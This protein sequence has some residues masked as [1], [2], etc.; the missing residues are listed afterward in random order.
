MIMKL[1]AR[2]LSL[3]LLLLALAVPGAAQISTGTVV[4]TVKDAQ[5]GVIPGATVIL[6]SEARGTRSAPA[7]TDERGDFVFV[8]M[9]ADTYT[10]E[11]SLPS[12][13][14]LKRSGVAVSPG[15]RI[16]IGT[17][18]LEIGGAT[19]TVEVK[20]EAPQIQSSS[21]ERSFSVNTDAVTNLPIATRNFADLINLTPGVV[22]GNRAGDSASTGG[23]ANNFMMDGVSTMEPGSNRLMIG[24]NVESIAEVKV[25]TSSYQA[26]FGRSS[27]LQVTAV[28]KSGTNR[29]RGSMY[30]VERNSDWNSNSR[31]NILNGDPKTTSRSRDWGYSIGGPV[32]KP[33]G[34]NKLFFFYAQEFQPRTT[35]NNVVR[36]RVP[37]A[38]ERAGDFSQTTDNNGALFPYI[39]DPLLTGTC[40]ATNQSACFA[41]GGVLG[42]IP[43]SRLY[44]IGQNILNLYPLPNIANV[45]AGQA[46]N[47]ELTRPEQ[48]IT[49]WQPAVR[50]DYQPMASLRGT[51]KYASWGQPSTPVIGSLP[52]FND[53]QMNDP[54]VPL[55]SASATY[56]ITPST[57][58]EVNVGHASHRQAGCGLNGTGANFCTAGFP[59]NPVSSRANT[60][61]T[62]LP[63]LFPD[64]NIV[65]PSYYQFE[66]LNEVDTPIWD[67]SRVLLPPAFQW[68]G[69]V[70]NSA[71]TPPNNVYP[72][73]ADFSAVTDFSGSVTKVLGRHTIKSGYY[74]QYA[75]KRQNQGNPFGTL[76]FGNDTNNPLD[77]QFGYANAVLGVFSSYQQASRFVEG[78]YVYNNDEAYIQDNWK[79]TSRLTLDYG[80]RFVHQ[81]P[82]YD[83][84]G[85]ASNFLP[86]KYAI[87]SAP[88]L[89]VAG[90]ANNVYPCSGANRQAMNPAT[91]EFLGPNSTLAIGAIVPNTGSPTNGLFR[92][93]EGITKTNFKWPALALAPRFGMAYDL[94]A[95]QKIVL[96]GGAGLFFDRP[97]GNS[98]FAQVLNPP[99]LQSVTVRYGQLQTLGSAGLTTTTPPALNVNEYDD[100][101]P[102]SWQ[103]NGGVQ[104]ALPWA[105]TLDTSYVGQHQFNVLQQLNLNA[106]DL[107]A[108]FLEQNRDPTLAA[109]STP[110]ATAVATDQ[111]RAIRGYNSITQTTGWL[112][113]TYHSIQL[114]VQR[115]FRNGVSFGFNDIIGLYDRQ[116]VAPRLQHAADG[117]FTVRDDQA[118][119]NKLLGNNRP[120][121][122]IMKAN[123]IWDLPD[124]KSSGAALRALGL[125]ANDWQL[126]GIWTAATGDAYSVGYSYQ[127][128]G[129]NVN[130]T[131]SPDYAGR[132]RIVGDPGNGCSSD[133]YRQLNAAAFQGPLVGST[134]LD[135]GTG[136]VRGCFSSALDLS[137][138][139][140][141]RLGGGRTI[142]LR[143]DMFNAPNEARITGRNTS[144]TLSSPTDPVTPQNLPFDASGNLI[145][146]RSLPRG[147]GFGVANNYQAPRSVQGQIRFTF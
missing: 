68:G 86:D 64:A 15:S 57:F 96:R 117:S 42:R 75:A 133:A 5:G 61:L 113:R 24:V 144:L 84:S 114:S 37:T 46:Y 40:S 1:F 21:G 14:L 99:T 137:I 30:D 123:F 76:N 81:Q 106:V 115:R 69:R 54:V 90:C 107:G 136:Y 125:I 13:K 8:N 19:E 120:Q 145:V 119:A 132:I 27:G 39:K 25:L 65:D 101:L 47:F 22:N 32:G 82:Q 138:Q 77:S 147:A 62:G 109:S 16:A 56:T 20:G 129:S 71:N 53:T 111:M 28:T 78:Q 74:K 91:G 102:S 67:G 6:I 9:P 128:G 48:S 83:T 36:F 59:T 118:E 110:G 52:G 146:A 44:A 94:T 134:G 98:V 104:L 70:A 124:L 60:G 11:V 80:M 63:Y 143:A 51:F 33:G 139:R 73:F 130:L 26:E 93:G 79:V 58:L 103:W 43:A 72:G 87:G 35:G 92:S 100:D 4:G 108:A 85:L 41:D 121:T 38:L 66:A 131:G 49:A 55:W 141:I 18:T 50:I 95:Q 142:Q 12:F 122:H 105:V 127:N 45:P 116:N 140:T 89:Y 10:V 88:R 29:F 17:L 126:A 2:T 7:I 31:V 3:A 97:S 112:S 23:G 34:N 135:S